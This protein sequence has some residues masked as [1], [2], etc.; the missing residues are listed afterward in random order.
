MPIYIDIFSWWYLYD[1]WASYAAR[2][3]DCFVEVEMAYI[4]ISFKRMAGQFNAVLYNIDVHTVDPKK[5]YYL[6]SLNHLSGYVLT[7]VTNY[8]LNA[9]VLWWNTYNK[10][11]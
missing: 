8:M 5:T 2:Y 6:Q 7:C 3:L 1:K 4:K 10:I 11:H 9:D